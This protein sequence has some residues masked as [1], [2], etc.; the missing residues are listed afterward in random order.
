MF[1]S[2]C[3]TMQLVV[4]RAWQC[5]ED[6]CRIRSSLRLIS[7]SYYAWRHHSVNTESF[8][9]KHHM[10]V[11]TTLPSSW[12][13]LYAINSRFN[14][15]VAFSMSESICL[16]PPPPRSRKLTFTDLCHL[17]CTQEAYTSTLSSNVPSHDMHLFLFLSKIQIC[18]RTKLYCSPCPEDDRVSWVFK[19]Q[20]TIDSWKRH[21]FIPILT[22]NGIN[23]EYYRGNREDRSEVK[24]RAYIERIC[25]VVNKDYGLDR[26]DIANVVEKM[27]LDGMLKQKFHDKG[28][29]S[30]KIE[31]SQA[32]DEVVKKIS[33]T[34]RFLNIWMELAHPWSA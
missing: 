17:A 13:I 25:D 1:R 14:F 2:I 20:S 8:I 19:R 18:D 3:M 34:I 30:Y 24:K 16:L 12:G 22:H 32:K 23:G 29:K 5:K 31:K 4:P 11:V 21:W 27:Y 7:F 15:P 28:S 33:N 9:C 26:G 10:C 6:L